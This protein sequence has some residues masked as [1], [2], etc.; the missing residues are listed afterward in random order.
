MRQSRTSVRP[1]FNDS[2]T[3]CATSNL[4]R[5]AED[6]G[7]KVFKLTESNYRQWNGV[8]ESNAESYENQLR[9]FSENPLV[10]QWIPKNVIYEVAIKEGYQLDCSIEQVEGLEQNTIFQVVSGN[11]E[12]TF[13]VSLDAELSQDEIDTLKLTT[14]D[15]FVCLDKGI[16]R[17]TGIEL[18]TPV[19]SENYLKMVG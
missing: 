7:V 6:L 15:L 10:D 11:K 13:Y 19:P 17:Y 5:E 12:Q 8:K 1:V 18:G 2:L 16:R 9:L 3:E 4:F 14:D